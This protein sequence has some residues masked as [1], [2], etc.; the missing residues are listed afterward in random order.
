MGSFGRIY[1][2]QNNSELENKLH[3]ATLIAKMM[4]ERYIL[5]QAKYEHLYDIFNA[6]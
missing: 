3:L 4:L 6:I 2:I 5:N 1:Y